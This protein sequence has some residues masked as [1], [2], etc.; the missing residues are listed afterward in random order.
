MSIASGWPG[1]RPEDQVIVDDL[2]RKASIKIRELFGREASIA[3]AV[4]PGAALLT[5]FVMASE[6]VDACAVFGDIV[7]GKARAPN[8]DPSAHSL[9]AFICGILDCDDQKVF[10][11]IKRA[12]EKRI[13]ARKAD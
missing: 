7:N 6:A 10:K 13:E 4:A 1:I 3:L 9:A 11:V 5:V 2:T 12:A 8:D